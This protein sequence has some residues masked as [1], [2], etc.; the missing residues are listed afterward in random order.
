MLEQLTPMLPTMQQHLQQKVHN[1][2]LGGKQKGKANSK[3]KK[4][5]ELHL[6]QHRY[7]TTN[8]Q[9]AM[10]THEKKKRQNIMIIYLFLNQ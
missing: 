7:V 2:N 6:G 9:Q 1:V 10:R 4:G 8:K 5:K 3:T